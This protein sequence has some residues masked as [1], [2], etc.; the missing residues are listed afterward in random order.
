RSPHETPADV[1][2]TICHD[3]S[4]DQSR[5]ARPFVQRAVAFVSPLQLANLQSRGRASSTKTNSRGRTPPAQPFPPGCVRGGSCVARS[6]RSSGPSFQ[7]KLRVVVRQNP[8]RLHVEVEILQIRVLFD[9]LRELIRQCRCIGLALNRNLA[10]R[11]IIGGD[12]HIP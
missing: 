1:R 8:R 10:S 11:L 5:A 9:L 3:S 7:T 12:T 4:K 6:A 2:A